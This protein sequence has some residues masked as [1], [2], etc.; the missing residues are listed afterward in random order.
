[1]YY[2]KLSIICITLLILL[3]IGMILYIIYREYKKYY[4]Q[5]IIRKKQ[6]ETINKYKDKL[7]N[8]IL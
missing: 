7:N 4:N 1:M 2:N 8:S 3:I 6:R 5:N